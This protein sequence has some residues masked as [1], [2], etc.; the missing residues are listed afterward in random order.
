MK[1]YYE[2][3]SSLKHHGIKGMRWGVR[4]YQNPDG[5]LTAAGR[6]RQSEQIQKYKDRELKKIDKRE[7][8][9]T[10]VLR[11]LSYMRTVD[12][13]R[14]K[15]SAYGPDS[16]QFKKAYEKVANKKAER[17]SEAQIA[18]L[19]KQAVRNMKPSEVSAEK[20]AVGKLY[21]DSIKELLGNTFIYGIHG[22]NNALYTSTRELKTNR[23]VSERKQDEI[24]ERNNKDARR[25]IYLNY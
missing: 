20:K 18:Y 2:T 3:S 23:R 22:P 14:Y 8:R 10:G 11:N 15:L 6:K 1:L 9:A 13:A 7:D 25:G 5:T 21:A 16:K 24:R 19:E 4:R 12:N 17:W